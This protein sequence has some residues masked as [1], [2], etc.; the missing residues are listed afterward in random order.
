MPPRQVSYKLLRDRVFPNRYAYA[1][2]SAG[3]DGFCRL[4]IAQSGGVFDNRDAEGSVTVLLPVAAS[5]HE[6]T[7]YVSNNS[8]VV[9]KPRN[10]EGGFIEVA[11]A[12][13]A[14]LTTGTIFSEVFD[15]A[16]TAVSITETEAGGITGSQ[17]G[18]IASTSYGLGMIGVESGSVVPQYNRSYIGNT[19]VTDVIVD[20]T[21]LTNQSDDGDVIGLAA[22]GAAYFFKYVPAETGTI[23]KIE[24]SCLELPT[25]ASN[26]GLDIDLF[27]N[28]NATRAY[29]FDISGATQVIAA[30]ADMVLGDTLQNL[31]D[32]GAAN[33]YYYLV[34][35]ATHTGDSTHTAGKL[36]IKFYGHPTF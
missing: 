14:A 31:D 30:G 32:H 1:S 26:V 6:F 9:I 25:A 21:G 2:L 29:D 19:I 23:F 36:M 8:P 4:D 33:D 17:A 24:M 18:T 12:N 11:N 28:S 22:G 13:A 5:G 27:S 20:L 3:D 16:V 34:T 35:G 7:F 10:E 15:G